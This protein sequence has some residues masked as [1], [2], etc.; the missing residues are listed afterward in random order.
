MT[1]LVPVSLVGNT[2]IPVASAAANGSIC[3]LLGIFQKS[4]NSADW[5][6]KYRKQGRFAQ[7]PSR[8]TRRSLKTS[9]SKIQ[10]HESKS[11]AQ[12]PSETNNRCLKVYQSWFRLP[13]VF[14]FF[15][16]GNLGN[17][18]FFYS[19]QFIFEYLS[20]SS[21]AFLSSD[22]L[23]KYQSGV[24]FFTAYVSQIFVTHL[25]YAFL[26]YGLNTIN[27]PEKYMK[28]LWGQFKVYAVSLVGATIL[29][30]YLINVGVDKTIAFFG[31]MTVFAF[32]N[33]FWISWMV[34]KAVQSSTKGEPNGKVSSRKSIA[35]TQKIMT[36]KKQ[37]LG[38]PN[39]KNGS[40]TW[41]DK[42]FNRGGS[43]VIPAPLALRVILPFASAHHALADD[44]NVS[45]CSCPDFIFQVGENIS[46]EDMNQCYQL[47]S[48]HMP[49]I[50]QGAFDDCT[51]Y[52]IFDLHYMSV[53]PTFANI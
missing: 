39:P 43:F 15:F 37:A 35:K 16:S 32:F 11:L 19:E 36:N 21:L 50:S 44:E 28:T 48:Q 9:A 20:S 40:R 27:S 23:E 8:W 42:I 24:S 53:R 52:G 33:Y 49:I 6:E 18:C 10:S 47:Y 41:A 22:F 51:K 31:T 34:E 45:S 30:T 17:V 5:K 46:V 4:G 38:K 7:S 1:G 2:N 14:R 13:Q 25:F 26:V 12:S 3:L 29:N